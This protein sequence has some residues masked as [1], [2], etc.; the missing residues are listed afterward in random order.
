MIGY[1]CDQLRRK[2]LDQ[3][4][5]GSQEFVAQMRE[6]AKLICSI[7][8]EVSSDDLREVADKFGLQP[9]HCNAWGAVFREEV[10]FKPLRF[11][12]SRRPSNHSR[13]ILVWKLA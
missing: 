11:E 2:G 6:I 3:A 7:T 1:I 8:G 9:K 13:R 12:K 4:E 5:R 10:G